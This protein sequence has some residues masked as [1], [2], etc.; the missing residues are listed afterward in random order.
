MNVSCFP[1]A[2]CDDA[3]EAKKLFDVV[4][5]LCSIFFGIPL[6]LVLLR[7][8]SNL[9]DSVSRIAY[10]QMGFERDIV[11]GLILA[12]CTLIPIVYTFMRYRLKMAL[13]D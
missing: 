4:S 5:L 7:M 9:S 3:Q 12:A 10:M 13:L 1:S 6:A 11:Y 8:M 2:E